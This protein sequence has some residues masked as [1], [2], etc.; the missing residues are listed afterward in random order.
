MKIFFNSLAFVSVLFFTSCEKKPMGCFTMSS[1]SVNVGQAVTFTDCSST[2]KGLQ[3]DKGK[4]ADWTWDFGDGNTGTGPSVTHSYSTIGEYMVTLIVRDED[5]DRST[6]VTQYINVTRPS[7]LSRSG[8]FIAFT[9]N[10]DGDYDIYIA[11]VDPNSGTLATSGL[12]F[13]SNPYNL[14][15]AFNA[16]TDKQAN[17]SPDGRI[18]L[19]SS[20]QSAG[21]ENIYAFYF[22]VDGTLSSST[23][24]LI[25]QETTAW[26]ENPS[27]SPDG[28]Y[29]IYDKRTDTNNDLI[30]DISDSRDLML[31]YTTNN[32]S[33]ISVDSTKQLTNTAGIDENNPKWSPIIA[34]QRIA[35]ESPSSSTATDHDVYVMDPLNTSNNINYNN[36]GSSGYPAWSPDCGSMIFESNSGNGGFYKIVV[37]SYPT[38]TSTTDIAKM[39]GKDYRYPTRVPNGNKIAFIEISSAIGNIYIIN[40]DGSGTAVKL[41][42]A[43]FDNADNSFPAW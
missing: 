37:A 14:T 13:S 4:P 9:S 19:F 34:V 32:I 36:P 3:L 30:V 27:F 35:Y 15:N 12:I 2:A 41:L 25:K 18:L 22:N 5:K 38:N 11:Q 26:D 39:A 17:W 23:P 40:S 28:K 24:T 29:I 16:L 8:K 6:T 42:P 1:S 7:D 10:Q 31:S 20:K 21:Q 43:A 33:T